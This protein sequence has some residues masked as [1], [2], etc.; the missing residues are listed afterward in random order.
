MKKSVGALLASSVVVVAPLDA[1]T[2]TCKDGRVIHGA[3]TSETEHDVTVG[4]YGAQ[5]VIPRARIS[6]I[7]RTT[8]EDNRL[9]EQEYKQLDE[10]YKEESS[11][12]AKQEGEDSQAESIPPPPPAE[13]PPDDDDSDESEVVVF[14]AYPP[15]EAAPSS[16]APPPTRP[17]NKVQERL[18]W[19]QKVRKAIHE[20]RVIPGMTE[21]QVQSAWGY[22]D[23]VHPVHG[24]YKYTNRWIYD[25]EGVGKVSV[26]FNNGLVVSVYQ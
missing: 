26:Y 17:P 24:A 22:P 23:L 11:E 7:T 9:L 20:K 15:S 13:P 1:D 19:E 8:A 4:L 21:R 12:S 18:A 6:S 3:I 25:R 10:H 2:V 5:V 14:P 16:G